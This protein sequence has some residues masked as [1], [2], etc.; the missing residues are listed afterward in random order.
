[1]DLF[2]LIILCLAIVEFCVWLLF[3]WLKNDFQWLIGKEDELIEF[4]PT[5]LEKFIPHGYHSVLGWSRKANTSKEEVI[6]SMGEYRKEYQ[7]SSYS[8]NSLNARANPG[9]EG[10]PKLLYAFGDSFAFARHVD[11]DQTWEHYLSQH[12]K[13]NVVNYGVGNYGLDQAVQK[14]KLESGS[15]SKDTKA[16]IMMVVP[17]TISRISTIWKHYSEY[18]NTFG[19]KGRYKLN[20]GSL[21]WLDNPVNNPEKFY[22][23]GSFL[24]W[25]QEND[26]SYNNKFCKDLIKFPFTWSLAKN[27]KRNIPLFFFLLLRK[28]L[29]FFKIE[30]EVLINKAWETISKRNNEY[31][32]ALY[33][34]RELCELLKAIVAEFK[35]DCQKLGVTP[36]LVV[37]PY[38]HD[39]FGKNNG[40]EIYY[41]P[42]YSSLSDGVKV[43]NLADSFLQQDDLESL[44]VNNFYGAHL[45]PKGNQ[46]VAHSIYHFFQQEKI[47]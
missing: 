27:S 44:Y 24:Q 5:A 2:I 30:N 45:S 14:L 35:R 40:D 12:S 6:K 37:A 25:I 20:N 13:S 7:Y 19:F 38:L 34:N 18:G 41:H 11:D 17:E 31:T 23:V 16:I 47:I 32:I 28:V 9:F 43:L 22:Q 26:Y 39:L 33:K 29:L 46:L 3:K 8:I 4:S 10:S 15:L 21:T 36:V 1:V 42:F